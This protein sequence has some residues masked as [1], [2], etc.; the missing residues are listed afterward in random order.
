MAAP[1]PGKESKLEVVELE[2][3]G[4]RQSELLVKM[5]ASGLCHSDDHIVK[6][7]LPSKMYPMCMGH[8]GSGVVREVG[9]HTPGWEVG[10]HVVFSFLPV[11]GRCRWCS[12]G[13]QG[14][15]DRGKDTLRGAR[16]DDTNSFRMSLVGGGSDGSPVGQMAGIS[17]FSEYTTVHTASAIKVGKDLPLDKLCL[18]GCG[19]GTGWGSAVYSAEVQPGDVVIV[20]GIGGIGINAIQGAAHAGAGRVIAVDPVAFKRESAMN[21]GATDACAD[22]AEADEL[23]KSLTNGQGADSAI[24]TVG[25]IRSEHVGQAFA[26]IRKGGTVVVTAVG[27]SEVGIPIPLAELTLWQKRLQGALFGSSNPLFDIPRQA[28]LYQ[29]GQLKLDELITRTYTL[30]EVNQGYQDMH[31]GTNI[32]GVIVYD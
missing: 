31:A 22:I 30:D 7:D 21:L 4:P 20:M 10:D 11:C 3:D 2:L 17:T 19:V 12:T 24:V 29:S 5:A 23:A 26:S 15:C 14:L 13:R 9:P 1:E 27:S 8:E 32:R 18:L 16:L 25:V 6:G 28:E